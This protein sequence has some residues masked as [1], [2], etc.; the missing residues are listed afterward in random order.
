MPI[1]PAGTLQSTWEG[2]NLVLSWE[3]PVDATNWSEVNILR[4][5]LYDGSGNV[6]LNVQMDPA[7][8]S[9]T[10]DAG[11]LTQAKELGDGLLEAWEVQTRAYD[12]DNR[13]FARSISLRLGIA[14]P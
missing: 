11:L 10:L 12:T 4:I 8:Q 14:S 13:N 7:A 2:D 3:N 6:L 9:V 5:S 1:V